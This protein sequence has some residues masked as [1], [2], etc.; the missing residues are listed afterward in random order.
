MVTTKFWTIPL[1]L[2]FAYLLVKHLWIS[3]REYCSINGFAMNYLNEDAKSETSSRGYK[4]A[5]V[6][7]VIACKGGKLENLWTRS[8]LQIEIRQTNETIAQR[9]PIMNLS[10]MEVRQD[11]EISYPSWLHL[12]IHLQSREFQLGTFTADKPLA[13]YLTLLSRSAFICCKTHPVASREM[14]D[15]GPL[16]VCSGDASSPCTCLAHLTYVNSL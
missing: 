15:L 11:K 5:G 8:L 2:D 10:Q 13:T 1:F 3:V 14:R 16:S 9:K 4:E 7:N 6:R 12:Y